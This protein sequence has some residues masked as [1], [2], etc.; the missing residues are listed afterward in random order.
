[1]SPTTLN[2]WLHGEQLGELQRL[3]NGGNRLRFSGEALQKWGTGTRLLSYSLP[4]ASK[5]VESAALDGW[6]DNLVAQRIL[7]DPSLR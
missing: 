7:H 5:R 6:L 3:R 2:V 4:M 1:M